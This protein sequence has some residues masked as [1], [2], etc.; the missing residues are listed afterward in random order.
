MPFELKVI[1]EPGSATH[2]LE[3]PLVYDSAEKGRCR[4]FGKPL[5]FSGAFFDA[6]Y[7]RLPECVEA[8][9]RAQEGV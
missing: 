6:G 7:L 4:G 5:E 1:A 2:C 8:E 9:R 3:C